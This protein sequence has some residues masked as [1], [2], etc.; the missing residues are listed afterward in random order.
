MIGNV[1]T[2]NSRMPINRICL[3]AVFLDR[4]RTFIGYRESWGKRQGTCACTGS[5]YRCLCI[6]W[7]NL[8]LCI[9]ANE[10]DDD[11]PPTQNTTSMMKEDFQKYKNASIVL[12]IM[13]EI[14]AVWLVEELTLTLCHSIL[15]HL[16]PHTKLFDSPR[17]GISSISSLGCTFSSV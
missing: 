12:K 3:H 2:N 1:Y 10:P 11:R 9:C 15:H 6:H 8:D 17:L 13:C 14:Y 7:R 16:H 4:R 5:F